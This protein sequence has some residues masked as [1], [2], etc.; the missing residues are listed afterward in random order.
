MLTPQQK[1]R[2]AGLHA[3][4]YKLI[5]QNMGSFAFVS[6][7]TCEDIVDHHERDLKRL[8]ALHQQKSIDPAKHIG[9]L[10]FWVRKLKPISAAFPRQLMQNEDGGFLAD[11][12]SL[13]REAE[14]VSIN[15]LVSIYL[16]QH[17]ILTYVK[18]GG[19]APELTTDAE[20][21]SLT[22]KINDIIN[23]ILTSRTD[24]GHVAGNAFGAF[25][26]DMRYRTFGPHHVVHFVNHVIY[27]ALKS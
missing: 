16:A 18:R 3:L 2:A 21:A 14:V 24:A 27:A 19:I 26:Y 1:K 17:L 5:A 11:T 7:Q 25:V 20:R 6:Y 13:P 8:I 22:S 4:L 12:T 10:V 9:Y 15:E 23:D